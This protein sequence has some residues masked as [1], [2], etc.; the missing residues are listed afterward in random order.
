M[1]V[2]ESEIYRCGFSKLRFWNKQA[3]TNWIINKSK[4]FKV[5][6]TIGDEYFHMYIEE[7]DPY[8]EGF[9]DKDISIYKCKGKWS[10]HIWVCVINDSEVFKIKKI[11]DILDISPE[12]KYNSSLGF[13]YLI[14][15]PH[16]F[17]IGSSRSIHSR[18]STFNVK[19]P[20]DWSFYKIYLTEDYKK[21]RGA[22]IVGVSSIIAVVVILTL[23]ICAASV[24][25][26]DLLKLIW[27]SLRW[28]KNISKSYINPFSNYVGNVLSERNKH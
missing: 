15:S 18:N 12:I 16:G 23:G 6:D 8:L 13:T 2:N 25:V 21:M 22:L 1:K 20:F 3:E 19:L 27:K 11:G 10:R 14:W 28:R 26:W 9:V 7:Y 17:K 4:D 24:C 5:L